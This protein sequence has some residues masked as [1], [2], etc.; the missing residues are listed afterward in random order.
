[1]RKFKCSFDGFEVDLD[2]PETYKHLSDDINILR[3][4]MF[5]EIGYSIVYM[6]YFPDRKD[7]FPKRKKKDIFEKLSDWYPNT[8]TPDKK[9]EINNCGY[10]EFIN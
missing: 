2:D 8:K 7:G 3:D 1:M 4:R 6:D 9:I 5:R 10:K